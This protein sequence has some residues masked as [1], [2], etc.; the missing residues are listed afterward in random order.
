MADHMIEVTNFTKKYGD[1]AAVDNV[2]FHVEAGTIFAFLGPNGPGK[3]PPLIR[4]VPF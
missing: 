2:S 4:S 1:F 3:V